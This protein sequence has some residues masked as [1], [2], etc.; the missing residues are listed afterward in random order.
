MLYP[1][2][3]INL[4]MLQV[5]GR[6]DLFLRLEIIKKC[7][8][9][10]PVILGVFY[11]INFMLWG[12]VFISFVA[13]FLNSYYSATLINYSTWS[14][15]KDILPTFLVSIFVS[16]CMWSITLLNYSVWITLPFQCAA[17]LIMA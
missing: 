16:A 5:K 8:A 17:G 14:Q 12:S 10:L 11:G 15:I 3:A 1:L 7:I 9:V 4:N 2:H 13:Y 6:S